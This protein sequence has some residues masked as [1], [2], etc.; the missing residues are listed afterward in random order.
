MPP[1]NATTEQRKKLIQLYAHSSGYRAAFDYFAR[2]AR[3]SHGGATTVD[4]L[5]NQI[6]GVERGELIWLFKQ[7]DEIGCGRFIVGRRTKA[8]RFEWKVKMPSVGKVAS[9]KTEHLQSQGNA[10][11]ADDSGEHE[12]ADGENEMIS[13]PYTLRKGM[14]ISIELPGDFTKQEAARVAKFIESLPLDGDSD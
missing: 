5:V 1:L 10:E 4:T 3:T 11:L 8:S 12:A 14:V 7:L 2:R 13:H 9:G 6:D